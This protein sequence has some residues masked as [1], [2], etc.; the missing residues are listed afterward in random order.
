M[1]LPPPGWQTATYL[2]FPARCPRTGATAGLTVAVPLAMLEDLEKWGPSHKFW[3]AWLLPEALENPVVILEGLNR[4]GY[5][6]GLCY[7]CVPAYRLLDEKTRIKP[8]PLKVFLTYVVSRDGRE[9]VLDWEWRFT[10][11]NRR[12]YPTHWQRDYT[13]QLWPPP[14]SSPSI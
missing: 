3:D 4:T 2:E 7:S 10:D 13:R 5:D 6:T 14:M 12:G 11:L 8:P 1:L 9:V